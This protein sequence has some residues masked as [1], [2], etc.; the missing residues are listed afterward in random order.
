[1][2]ATRQRSRKD[3]EQSSKSD[4]LRDRQLVRAPDYESGGSGVRISS[5]AP[6]LIPQ[7]ETFRGRSGKHG[8]APH[9][10]AAYPVLAV[11]GPLFTELS[12]KMDCNEFSGLV[13]ETPQ[14]PCAPDGGAICT[15]HRKAYARINSN[16]VISQSRRSRCERKFYSVPLL[17][18]KVTSKTHRPQILRAQSFPS[19]KISDPENRNKRTPSFAANS[20]FARSLAS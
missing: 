5:G 14:S 7:C 11:T 19:L 1:M 12:S 15:V 6:S 3:K 13:L 4:T 16:L 8:G 17:L 20:S 18:C 10:R 2:S 9:S